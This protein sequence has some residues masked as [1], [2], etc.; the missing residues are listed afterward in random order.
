MEVIAKILDINDLGINLQIGEEKFLLD[1]FEYPWFKNAK[2]EDVLNFEYKQK[3]E[4]LR[5]PNLDV[6]LCLDGVR[7]PEKYPL[8]W[9]DK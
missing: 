6:D 1:Y 8:K 4:H 9:N 3:S 2:V 5:W 7:H